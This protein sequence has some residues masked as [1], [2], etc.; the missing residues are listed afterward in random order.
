[1]SLV[2]SFIQFTIGLNNWM[3][4]RVQLMF[5]ILTLTLYCLY[6]FGSLKFYVIIESFYLKLM[7]EGESSCGI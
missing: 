3:E 1:M 7:L 6:V 4:H 2:S 5:G